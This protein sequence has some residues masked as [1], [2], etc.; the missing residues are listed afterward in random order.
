M[1]EMNDANLRLVLS[2]MLVS[3]DS[4]GGG[5]GVG[6][7]THPWA[8]LRVLPFRRLAARPACRR[9]R[10]CVRAPPVS[11]RIASYRVVGPAP[12]NRRHVLCVQRLLDRLCLTLRRRARD[13]ARFKWRAKSEEEEEQGSG[14]LKKLRIP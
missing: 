6:R 1:S 8:R 5:G 13:L 9:A 3:V 2:P 14:S 11:R 10:V 12:A 7:G 4:A